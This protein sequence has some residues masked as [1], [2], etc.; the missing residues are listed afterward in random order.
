M[1]SRALSQNIEK[2]F[3]CDEIPQKE[4]FFVTHCDSYLDYELFVE[5][6]ASIDAD[7]RVSNL[8]HQELYFLSP[9]AWR[10]LLP[11][12]LR[13][14]LTEQSIHNQSEIEFFIYALSSTNGVKQKLSLLTDEEINCLVSFVLFIKQNSSWAE[15]FLE[16]IEA[17]LT[18]L[19]TLRQ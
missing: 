7:Y 9:A 10:W 6:E 18:F 14:G 15:Y 8:L 19:N 5:A 3:P 12:F 16:D 4:L 2:V 11:F 17:A 13:Y 1:N